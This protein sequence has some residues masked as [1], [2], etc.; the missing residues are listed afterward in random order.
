MSLANLRAGQLVVVVF[1]DASGRYVSGK[2]KSTGSGGVFTSKEVILTAD[3]LGD[4]EFIFRY[5]TEEDAWRMCVEN[6]DSGELC[7][8]KD[9]LTYTLEHLH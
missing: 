5:L 6:P 3:I 9:S 8:S 1:N 4:A 7:F 2:I